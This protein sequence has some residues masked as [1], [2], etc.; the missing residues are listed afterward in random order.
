[1]TVDYTRAVAEHRIDLLET[2]GT[3][4]GLI[5]LDLQPDHLL[6]VNLAVHPEWQ[7]R[8]FGSRLLRHADDVAR[9]GG[10]TELR[11]YTNSL[12]STNV[13]LYRRRGYIV[14]REE[15]RG[16]GWTVMHMARRLPPS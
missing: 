15:P 9:E 6:I 14:T 5:E 13:D 4:A 8:G 1:M 10:L 11:L 7:G 2:G 12:M 16:P 3:L